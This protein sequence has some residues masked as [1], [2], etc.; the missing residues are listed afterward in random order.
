MYRVGPIPYGK[1]KQCVILIPLI[2]KAM[3][4]GIHSENPSADRRKFVKV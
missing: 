4:V 1:R 3:I 2:H